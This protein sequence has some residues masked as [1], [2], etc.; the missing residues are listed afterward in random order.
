M[1]KIKNLF[2]CTAVVFALTCCTNVDKQFETDFVNPPVSVQTSI[3][4]F[5]IQGHISKDGVIKDLQSMK[6][7][8]INRALS[9]MLEDPILKGVRKFATKQYKTF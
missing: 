7:A 8:G 2:I 1:K 9:R 4:W 5:W 6:A 3:Y